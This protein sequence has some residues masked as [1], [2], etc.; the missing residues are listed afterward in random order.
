M[1]RVIGSGSVVDSSEGGPGQR[2][3]ICR[4]AGTLVPVGRN[5]FLRLETLHSRP[6]LHQG[7]I[8]RTMVVSFFSGLSEP[9]GQAIVPR[10]PPDGV[11]RHDPNA[12]VFARNCEGQAAEAGKPTII[13]IDAMIISLT[14]YA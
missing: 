1:G 12:P 7:A 8:D 9:F 5:P 3:A 13:M 2:A 14:V 11:S 6:A 4:I 10:H